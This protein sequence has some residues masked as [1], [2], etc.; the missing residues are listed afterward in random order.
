MCR[1]IEESWE[2]GEKTGMQ[3]G[4]QQ[5][6][7]QGIAALISTCK[8]LGVSFEGTAEKPQEKFALADEEAQKEMGLYW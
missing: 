8:E 3:R 2:N 5:G 4:I 6:I 1:L 7:Q